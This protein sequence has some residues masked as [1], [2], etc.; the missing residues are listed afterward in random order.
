MSDQPS[1]T[2]I[3]NQSTPVAPGTTEDI[4]RRLEA[5]QRRRAPWSQQAAEEAPAFAYVPTVEGVG[6]EEQGPFFQLRALGDGTPALPVFT[7]ETLFEAQLG[8]QPR[9]RVSLLQL[10]AVVAREKVNVVINPTLAA[11]ADL[12]D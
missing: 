11:G 4:E 7:D 3:L 8:E 6:P 10:L 1:L 9:V 5:G 12:A 2:E